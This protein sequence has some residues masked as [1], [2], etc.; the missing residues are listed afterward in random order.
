MLKDKIVIYFFLLLNK[1]IFSFYETLHLAQ[2]YDVVTMVTALTLSLPP[3]CRFVFHTHFI[4]SEFR[5]SFSLV[6]DLHQAGCEF[7]VRHN[8]RH[9][10]ARGSFCERCV[11]VNSNVISYP[12][13]H[14]C[15]VELYSNYNTKYS[16]FILCFNLCVSFLILIIFGGE[17]TDLNK[18]S[19][20]TVS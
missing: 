13:Q 7:L 10:A 1:I 16:I 15:S 3:H 20:L 4:S 2:A 8:V 17:L 18:I 5:L 6:G 11:P 19:F 14:K 12:L 9:L